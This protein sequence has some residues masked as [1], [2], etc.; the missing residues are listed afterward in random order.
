LPPPGTWC[1]SF[2]LSPDLF[3]L[4]EI[5]VAARSAGGNI[6]HVMQKRLFPS[7]AEIEHTSKPG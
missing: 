6:R 1:R 4:I 2:R 3:P 7:G 5:S